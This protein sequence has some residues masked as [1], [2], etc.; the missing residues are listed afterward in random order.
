M[1][2]RSEELLERFMRYAAVTTQ[3][4]AGA[5]V[6]PSTPGQR[7]LADLLAEELKGLGLKQVEVSEFSVVTGLLP[8]NLPAGA[9]AP[10]VGWCCHLDTVDA[11]LSPDIHPHVVKNYQGGDVCLNAEKDLWMRV[12]EHPEVERYKGDD[13]IVSDG[14]SVLGADNKSAIANVMTALDRKSVV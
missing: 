11:G 5:K 8:S 4:L 3:S 12:S 2:N 13:L 6:V 1:I 10:K 14:T 7:V 9:Q